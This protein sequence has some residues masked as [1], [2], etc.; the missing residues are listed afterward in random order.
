[1][2]NED[3]K[4]ALDAA[5]AKLEKD[6]GKGT[7]MKLGDPKAQVTVETIPTGSLSL[8][9]ALGLG[10][11][12]R[13]RIVEVYGPES[14]GKT[15]VALH[16][17]AEVQ[18]RGGIAGFI[19]AEHALDPVYAKN[20][21]V[22]IDELY[23]SQPDSGD[24]ALEITETMVRSGA[25]DII[26]VD[27]VAALV[28]KQEIEGDMGDSHVGLQARLMS[29]ALRKLTPVISKSNCVVIFINQLRE[30][31]GVMFGNPET[32][33]GGRALKFYASIRMDVRRIETL[34]QSGDM[35]GNRTRVKVVKNK[36]APPFKEAEFD[37]MFGKGI[38]K[39]G[40]I[41]DLAVDL[42]LVSKSGAWFAYNGDKIG[43][44]RENAKTY[45]KEHPEVMEELEAK[46][47]SHYQIGEDAPLE[48]KNVKPM[49]KDGGK[50]GG[51]KASGKAKEPEKAEEAS[52]EPEADVNNM[53][54][55]SDTE[56]DDLV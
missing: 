51:K 11:V 26:V 29:Q 52:E 3:K 17:I 49:L 19:D 48:D 14:S 44:G 13:G 27:S 46:I 33:T 2:A 38:S 24:Q 43:Q 12:P 53:S 10:G 6:F 8:D 9:L 36:I 37:I 35:V 20:I 1:M 28:P 22:D 50:K 4:K 32:T 21:G 56:D 7:V 18:K 23:I 45:L 40:D 55:E 34:K 15:T 54:K 16:M 39:E 47:R 41:L 42:K 30:K 5:I 25:M 31:V